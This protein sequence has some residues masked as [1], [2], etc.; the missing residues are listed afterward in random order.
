MSP[1]HPVIQELRDRRPD[2]FEAPAF[3]RS[4]GA[5]IDACLRL[6][7]KGTVETIGKSAGGRSIGAVCYGEFEPVESTATISSALASDRPGCFFDPEKRERPVLALIGAIHGGETEGVAL[8]LSLIELLETGKDSMGKAR[9][10]LLEKLHKIRL[11]L[12]PCLNPDGRAA[13]GVRH[14]QDAELD[15]LFLVQQGLQAD[16]TPLKGRKVKEIQPIPPESM[17]FLGGYYNG[18]GVNLQHDDF[19]GP[20]LAPENQA[21]A[22]LFRREIPDSFLSCHAHGAPAAMLVPNAYL[23]PGYQRRQV[24]AAGFILA[25]LHER[26]IPFLPPEQIVTPPWSFYFQTW[27]SHMTGATPLLFEFCHGLRVRPCPLETILESGFTVLEAWLD[28][29]LLFGARPVSR[30]L[31]GPV[32]TA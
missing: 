22:R 3:W 26:G 28:H 8:T 12:V 23:A 31:F 16:G 10:A 20:E 9:P 27:L 4:E 14:L 2:L 7:K 32:R 19:F 17:Q 24:E 21:I 18:K 15:D 5:E 13:A 6:V 11:C 30:E 25:K 29:T 1:L